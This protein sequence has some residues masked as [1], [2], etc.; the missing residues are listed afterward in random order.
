MEKAIKTA[1]FILLLTIIMSDRQNVYISVSISILHDI[2]MAM[3]S[4]LKCIF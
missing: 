2:E 4:V 1:G 3:R